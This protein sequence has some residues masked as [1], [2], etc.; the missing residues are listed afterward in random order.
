MEALLQKAGQQPDNK[1]EE[2]LPIPPIQAQLKFFFDMPRDDNRDTD[3]L[4]WWEDH[5]GSISQLADYAR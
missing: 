2:L 1:E 3:I 4:G 5:A